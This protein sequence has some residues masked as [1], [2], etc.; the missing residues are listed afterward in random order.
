MGLLL[1]RRLSLRTGKRKIEPNSPP[2]M[3]EALADHH[4]LDRGH[5]AEQPDVLERPAIPSFSMI[6]S[7]RLPVMLCPRARSAGRRLVVARQHVEERRLPRAVGT[8]DRDDRALGHAEGDVADRGQAAELLGHVRR[9][10]H[11]AAA[12]LRAARRSWWWCPCGVVS[13]SRCLRDERV[14]RFVVELQAARDQFLW[15]DDHHHE[16]E[17][18]DREGDLGDVEVRPTQLGTVAMTSGMGR[19]LM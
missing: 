7:G 16:Q 19:E 4:V 17:A 6:T 1:D 14:L 18:V 13:S 3:R 8:D 11:Q 12:G 15:P 5:G 2:F 10:E 9:V